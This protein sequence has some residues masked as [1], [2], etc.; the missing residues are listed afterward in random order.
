MKRNAIARIILFSLGIIILVGILGASILV[1]T[2]MADYRTEEHREEEYH[3]IASDEAVNQGIVK[4]AIR[5]IEIDWVSGSITVEPDAACS[6]I[7]I[8]ET[9]TVDKKYQMVYSTSGDTLKIQY[10]KDGIKFPSFGITINDSINK[11]L[12]IRVPESWTC[13]TLEIDTA[14]AEVNLSNLIISEFDFDGASGICT[15]SNCH[16][17]TMDLDTASGD[18]IFEGT[19][20][21]LDCDAASASCHISVSNK[22]NSIDIDTASGDLELTLPEDCGFSCKMDTLSGRFNSDFDTASFDGRHVY[23]DG[24]CQ[25]SVSAMSGDVNIQKHHGSNS[26]ATIPYCT[27][28]NCTDSSHDHSGICTDNDCEEKSHGHSNHH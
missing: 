16:V 18:I 17:D 7:V 28:P 20:D 21:H 11:D 22:P 23:G 1:K 6:D 13:D 2:Y 25:I 15:I 12:I 4:A 5:N 10:C 26:I 8:S 24:H 3:P 9:G 19:L 14:S 27:D